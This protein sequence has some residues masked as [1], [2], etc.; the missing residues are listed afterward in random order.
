MYEDAR[1]NTASFIEA[2]ENEIVF[3]RNATESLNLAAY[4]L[5]RELKEGDEILIS[6]M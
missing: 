6:K 3:T 5:T 1:K 4:T 2:E